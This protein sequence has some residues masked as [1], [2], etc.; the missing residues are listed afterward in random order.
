LLVTL[1]A[2]QL[3]GKGKEKTGTVE[4]NLYSDTRF[5]FT[6][7]LPSDWKIGKLKK[8]LNCQRLVAEKKNPRIPPQLRDDPSW[9]TPPTL[10]I[11][12]DS[13]DLSAEQFFAFLQSDST[14][15]ELKKKIN[16]TTVLF[17]LFSRDEPDILL[18]VA[19][20]LGGLPAWRVKARR[21][22]EAQGIQL[23]GRGG[24][25]AVRD[26]VSGY[27]YVIRG[28]GWV[29]YLELVCEN[30][31]LPVLEEKFTEIMKSFTVPAPE[32]EE[33]DAEEPTEG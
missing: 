7:Q 30:Q 16:S 29:A 22:Y 1:L 23:S 11:F 19:D 12:A 32:Q 9:A 15:S 21:Q 5:G 33:P 13:N 14:K 6:I 31:F 18:Q 17:D 27:A 4:D 20:K 24:T 26:F 25:A 8:E 2:P 3:A 10:M 28:E